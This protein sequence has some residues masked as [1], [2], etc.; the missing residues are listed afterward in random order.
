MKNTAKWMILLLVLVLCC[1]AACGKKDSASPTGGQ[2]T[3]DQN[4]E[5]PGETTAPLAEGVEEWGDSES[6]QHTNTQE[7]TPQGDQQ[8]GE[9]QLPTDD[10]ELTIE[11]YE[12][13]ST[14]QQQAYF[15]SFDTV[16]A[17]Y[18]WLEE[19]EANRKTDNTV[20]GDGSLNL[21]DYINKNP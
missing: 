3:P 6:V 14:S 12:A 7:S 1:T 10:R 20:T 9:A 5:T 2:T 4:I 18:D 21:G 15:M 8:Q 19:A 11:E 13:L 16:D 17:F